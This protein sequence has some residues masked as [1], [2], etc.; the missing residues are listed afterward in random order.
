MATKQKNPARLTCHDWITTG[1]T[2]VESG[3]SRQHDQRKKH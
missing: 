2:P 3:E 1:S